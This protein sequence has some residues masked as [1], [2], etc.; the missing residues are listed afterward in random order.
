MK[1]RSARQQLMVWFTLHRV[2]C[3][4]ADAGVCPSTDSGGL[5]LMPCEVLKVV[6]VESF[7]PW[8]VTKLNP[9]LEIMRLVLHT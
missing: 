7:Q 9:Q 6:E 4:P 5:C 3:I 2:A 1:T 8:L